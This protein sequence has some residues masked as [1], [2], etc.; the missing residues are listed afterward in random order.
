MSSYLIHKDS[1]EKIKMSDDKLMQGIL[2]Q[3]NLLTTLDIKL[4]INEAVSLANHIHTNL[5]K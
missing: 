4:N 3:F 1:V 5:P 2:H